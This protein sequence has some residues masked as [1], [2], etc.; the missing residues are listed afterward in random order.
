[1]VNAVVLGVIVYFLCDVGEYEG[2]LTALSMP[3]II[4]YLRTVYDYEYIAYLR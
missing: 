1:M 3:S 4:T 2:L